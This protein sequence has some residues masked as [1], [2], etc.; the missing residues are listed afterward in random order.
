VWN[1]TKLSGVE[2]ASPLYKQAAGTAPHIPN[3]PC[4]SAI[5]VSVDILANIGISFFPRGRW[6]QHPGAGGR[7]EKDIQACGVRNA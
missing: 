5:R 3:R 2:Q 4:L 6:K 7:A 1:G